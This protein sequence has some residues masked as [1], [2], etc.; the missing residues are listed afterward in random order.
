MS[1]K[2]DKDHKKPTKRNHLNK[3]RIFMNKLAWAD[4]KCPDGRW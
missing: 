4:Q 3:K 1:D 2:F